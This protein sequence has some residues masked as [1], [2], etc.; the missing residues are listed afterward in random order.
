MFV[1]QETLFETDFT[2]PKC[3]PV[4]CALFVVFQVNEEST[5]QVYGI[6]FAQCSSLYCIVNC[7]VCILL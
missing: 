5:F 6:S 3:Q 1:L 7:I 4:E 2:C